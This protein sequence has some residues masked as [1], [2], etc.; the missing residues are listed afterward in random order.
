M[1]IGNAKIPIIL[2]K[3]EINKYNKYAIKTKPIAIKKLINKFIILFF[4]FI[5]YFYC[6]IWDWLINI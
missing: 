2:I 6:I 1:N 4:I 3:N 5:Y